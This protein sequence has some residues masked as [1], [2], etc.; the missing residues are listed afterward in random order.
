M[1]Y[2]QKLIMGILMLS[3]TIFLGSCGEEGTV[4]LEKS[5]KDSNQGSDKGS[6]KIFSKD[7]KPPTGTKELIGGGYVLA[8]GKGVG[9]SIRMWLSKEKTPRDW[10]E[11]DIMKITNSHLK[12]LPKSLQKTFP[13]QLTEIS[14]DG[15]KLKMTDKDGDL[16]SSSDNGKNWAMEEFAGGSGTEA[17]PYQITNASQLWLVRNH[18]TSHFQLI[19]DLDLSGVAEKEGFKPIGDYI[20]PFQGRFNGNKKII[21]NLKINGQDKDNVGLF[22]SV[23]SSG[24]IYNIGLED[25]DVKG[26]NNVGGLVGY[27]MKRVEDSYVTGKVKGENTVGG[28][29]G[30][31]IYSG[32]IY[33]SYATGAVTGEKVLGGLVGWNLG[34]IELSYAAGKVKG[35]WD[36]RED[37]FGGLV[38]YNENGMIKTSYAT[39][40]VEGRI[41]IG[42]F[43]GEN[44]GVIENSYATGSVTGKNRIGGFVGQFDCEGEPNKI[45]TSYAA[46]TVT[47][48][49]R[50]NKDRKIG[51][52]VGANECGGA[53]CGKNYWKTTGSTAS[54]GVGNGPGTNVEGKTEADLKALTATV[55]GWDSEIWDFKAFKAGQYPKLKWQK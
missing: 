32:E 1:D 15:K 4:K 8:I 48:K 21:R 49:G 12:K 34:D 2:R 39:G 17:D 20:D 38:G 47:G 14:F 19:E 44:S 36:S 33:R 3:S 11:I 25:V 51:G 16:W 53:I 6:K 24:Y 54:K 50:T 30:K 41:H 37:K 40:N 7:S 5:S 28:L 23:G 29:V 35:G 26:K 22:G 43:V 10:T 18:L 42:G 9:G 31:S 46:G 13:S 52:F 27:N 45:E 55:T